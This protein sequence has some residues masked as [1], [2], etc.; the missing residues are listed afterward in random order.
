MRSKDS[1][2][3][4]PCRS[5]TLYL[6]G[7][8]IPFPIDHA[9]Y[10]SLPIRPHNLAVELLAEDREPDPDG[11]AERPDLDKVQPPFLRLALADERLGLTEALDELHLGQPPGIA[12]ATEEKLVAPV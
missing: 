3:A 8:V 7:F 12:Q 1:R 9:G 10:P 5:C 11:G 4:P 6:T 2:Q